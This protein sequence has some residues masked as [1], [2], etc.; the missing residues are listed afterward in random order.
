MCAERQEIAVQRTH[1]HRRVGHALRT[2]QQHDGADGVRLRDHLRHRRQRAEHVGH[3]REGDELWLHRVEDARVGGEV[4]LALVGD[5]HVLD[6]GAGARRG[7]L[8]GHDVA[9]VLHL[10]QHDH[11][12]FVEIGVGPGARDEVDG[13]GGVAR[14]DD[15]A[16]AARIDEAR[17]ALARAL[18]RGSSLLAQRI[19]AAM[20]VG[21]RRAREGV[22]GVEDLPRLLCGGGAIQKDQRLA[23]NLA[24]EDGEVRAGSEGLTHGEARQRRWGSGFDRLCHAAACS[25]PVSSEP[26]PLP[27]SGAER[28]CHPRPRYTVVA[29]AAASSFSPVSHS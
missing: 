25:L 17:D 14:V 4:Q 26:H 19:R 21:V 23:M 18:I 13:L 3:L 6:V 27:L 20:D 15:L 8:P 7:K 29:G 22:H 1:V 11:V 28:G 16:H 5:G 2:V 24:G 10:G 9:V 12:V